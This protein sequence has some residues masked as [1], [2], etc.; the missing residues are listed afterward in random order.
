MNITLWKDQMIGYD[1]YIDDCLVHVING[2]YAVAEHCLANTALHQF[3]SHML[4]V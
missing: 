2:S 3:L 1:L 4:R